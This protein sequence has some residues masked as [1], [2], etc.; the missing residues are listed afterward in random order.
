MK[1]VTTLLRQAPL[2]RTSTSEALRMTLG[3]TLAGNAVKVVLV[4]DGVFLLQASAPEKI[5]LTEIYRH[6]R[7]LQ[8]LGCPFVAEK[9]SMDERGIL[10]PVFPVHQ[11]DRS[12]VAEILS[13][14]DLVI[15]C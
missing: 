15:G 7:T 13:G 1:Q 14:S 3:L 4:E 2:G 11:E 5:G 9:E 6:V 8:E 10:D 12:A